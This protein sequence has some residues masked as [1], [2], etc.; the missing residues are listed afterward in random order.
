MRIRRSGIR[1]LGQSGIKR[2]GGVSIIS[3]FVCLFAC[4]LS[5]LLGRVVVAD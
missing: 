4:L 5:C 2:I 3:S 1:G